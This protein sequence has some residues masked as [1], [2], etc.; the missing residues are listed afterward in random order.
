MSVGMST[1]KEIKNSI[2]VLKKNG[3]SNNKIAILQCNT[4][5]PT[6]LEDVNL[7]V[8]T[9]FKKKLNIK[10][11]GYSDHTKGIEISLAAVAMGAKIIEKH[12][13]NNLY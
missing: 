4:E 6:P 5:Y 3:T 10:N 1:I 11:I 8:I 9:T 13:S 12:F 7:N 2:A